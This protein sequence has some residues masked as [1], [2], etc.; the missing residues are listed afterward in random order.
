M[1]QESDDELAESLV[2]SG[3][4]WFVQC[5]K[6]SLAWFFQVTQIPASDHFRS[7]PNVDL[8]HKLKKFLFLRVLLGR[9]PCSEMFPMITIAGLSKEMCVLGWQILQL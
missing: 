6:L 5:S 8:G 2:S 1:A 4:E 9:R 7:P 3:S